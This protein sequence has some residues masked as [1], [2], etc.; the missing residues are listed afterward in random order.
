[1]GNRV[2]LNLANS[3]AVSLPFLYETMAANSQNEIKQVLDILSEPR[4]LPVLF[5]CEHGKDRT[6]V[7]AALVLS[8]AGASGLSCAN[9]DVWL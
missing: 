5:H 9:A 2:V 3:G 6:G 4:N 1:M 8:C 7:I